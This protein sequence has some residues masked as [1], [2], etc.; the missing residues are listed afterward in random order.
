M[1]SAIWP[2][3]VPYCN[4]N[5]MS[6]IIYMFLNYVKGSL[7]VYLRLSLTGTF[8]A[9]NILTHSVWI[10][11][12]KTSNKSIENDGW[13]MYAMTTLQTIAPYYFSCSHLNNNKA[14]LSDLIAAICL[15]KGRKC[16][17]WVEIS[18]YLCDLDLWYLTL[19][20]CISI[21]SVCGNCSWN[22][23]TIR[24]K[25]RSEKKCHRPTDGWREDGG[26]DGQ[27]RSWSQ[28]KLVCW[29]AAI[30]MVKLQFSGKTAWPCQMPCF[31]F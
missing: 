3:T 5:G 13:Q 11:H 25:K 23:M 15:V 19:T 17:N 29:L 20:F 26:T 16:A 4:V 31:V 30:K 21:T 9:M 14:N 6:I 27:N 12:S 28:L 10:F 1:I 22:F 18:F 8:C 7:K 24:W 2:F